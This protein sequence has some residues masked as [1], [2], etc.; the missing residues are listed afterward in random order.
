MEEVVKPRSEPSFRDRFKW[1]FLLLIILSRFSAFFNLSSLTVLQVQFQ[2]AI[3]MSEM[4]F[5]RIIQLQGVPGLLLSIFMGMLAD[6]YGAWVSIISSHVLS[7]S[8]QFFICY[9]IWT[10]GY[11]SVLIGFVLEYSGM[12]FGMVGYNQLIR[13]WYR[14]NELSRANSL[15]AMTLTLSMMFCDLAYPSLFNSSGSLSFPFIVGLGVAT[16]SAVAGVVMVLIH[17]KMISLKQITP[18]AQTEVKKKRFSLE[19]VKTLSKLYWLLVIAFPLGLMSNIASKVYESKFLQ[20]RFNFEVT[21]AGYLLAVSRVLTMIISSLSGFWMDKVGRLPFFM[22]GSVLCT[23]I[24]TIG[25]IITPRCDRCFLP[26]LPLVIMSFASGVL[27][28]ATNSAMMRVVDPKMIGT[29]F[30][31]SGTTYSVAHIII[32][33]LNGLIA[34][35]TYAE[36]GYQWVFAVNTLLGGVAMIFLI[37]LHVA[38]L[39]GQKKLQFVLGNRRASDITAP[40]IEELPSEAPE[41]STSEDGLSFV[42]LGQK[43]VS[44]DFSYM[45]EAKRN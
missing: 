14:D 38:D 8:G 10:S 26:I 45:G 6:Y 27:G 23:I 16:F 40:I 34:E 5:S 19:Y 30:A 29:T 28:I 21:T 15:S 3:N 1:W 18:T 13:A 37:W 25:N 36:W 42:D 12:E 11:W 35:A 33:W 7:V 22:M 31:I 41:S 39:I 43:N 44:Y 24:G 32:P 4:D 20:K 2:T 17:R 9:G